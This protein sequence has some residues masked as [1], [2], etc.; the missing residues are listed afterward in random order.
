[1]DQL[2]AL[3][4]RSQRLRGIPGDVPNSQQTGAID[5]LLKSCFLSIGD[6]SRNIAETQRTLR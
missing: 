6:G 3:P 2:S 1:M 4:Q 5:A